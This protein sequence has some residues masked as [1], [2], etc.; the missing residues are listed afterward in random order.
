MLFLAAVIMPAQ[1]METD[2]M[3]GAVEAVLCQLDGKI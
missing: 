2:P 3:A 1:W